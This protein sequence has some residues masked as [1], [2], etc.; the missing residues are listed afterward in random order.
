MKRQRIHS[1]SSDFMCTLK[2]AILAFCSVSWHNAGLRKPHPIGEILIKPSAIDTVCLMYGNNVAKKLDI[3]QWSNNTVGRRI[4][5]I[6][7]N[8]KK[9][10]LSSI[11]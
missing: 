7:T 5:S 3:V 4:A 2:Q 6:S 8:V 10:L 9:Q 11:R 1:N